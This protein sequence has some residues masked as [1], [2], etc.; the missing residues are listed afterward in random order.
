MMQNSRST[1]RSRTCRN[2]VRTRRNSSRERRGRRGRGIAGL[3]EIVA[4]GAFA[5]AILVT[6][7]V[8]L[9]SDNVQVEAPQAISIGPQDTLWDIAEQHPAEGLTTAQTVQAIM[10]LNGLDVASVAVGQQLLVPSTAASHE[11]A[12][13]SR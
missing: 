5:L 11:A 4:I 8:Y 13:A 9:S 2:H 7:V 3:I 1:Y 6:A 10:D 12:V